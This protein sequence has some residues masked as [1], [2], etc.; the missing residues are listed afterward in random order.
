[1]AQDE[2]TG[3]RN[4]AYSAWHRRKSISRFV[5]EEKAELL[6]MID[7]DVALYV[8]YANNSKE[9]LLLMETAQDIGQDHKPT[10]VLRRLAEKCDPV[11]PAI[12]LLYTCGEKASPASAPGEDAKDITRFRYRIIHPKE[13]E[14]ITV[15]PREWAEKL[16][17]YRRQSYERNYKEQP[18]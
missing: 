4:P 9:P 8:D 14:W 12:L 10:T 13:T 16:C 6:G 18:K 7:I 5:N 17:D 11:V 3:K 2:I 1:M 15:S